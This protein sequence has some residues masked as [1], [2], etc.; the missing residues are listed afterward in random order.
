MKEQKKA[1]ALLKKAIVKSEKAKAKCFSKTFVVKD[2][3]LESKVLGVSEGA[4]E[5]FADIVSDRVMKWAERRESIT[6]DDV[7]TQIAKEIKKYSKDLAFVYKNR[8]K[9]I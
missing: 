7:N 6:E 3:M 8:G 2:I 9:I 1:K 4:A 5:K